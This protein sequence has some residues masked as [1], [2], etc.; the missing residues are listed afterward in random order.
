MIRSRLKILIAEAESLNGESFTYAKLA[1]QIGLSKDT[2]NRL[3]NN[4]TKR[5]DFS[6]L[7]Q[8]C[9][10]FKC[11]PGDILIYVPNVSQREEVAS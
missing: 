4:D 10:H 9:A 6:T 8:L 2:L 1:Q 7:S 11:Q 5:I 3:A